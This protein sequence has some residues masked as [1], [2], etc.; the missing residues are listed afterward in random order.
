MSKSETGNKRAK[1]IVSMSNS[2]FRMRRP[3]STKR[4]VIVHGLI[5]LF[6]EVITLAIILLLMGLTALVVLSIIATGTNV[7]SIV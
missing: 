5:A 1:E 6:L 3:R 7:A 2:F 4:M